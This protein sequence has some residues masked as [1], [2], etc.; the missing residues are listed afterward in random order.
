MAHGFIGSP[1]YDLSSACSEAG[2]D[3]EA[4]HPSPGDRDDDGLATAK[5]IA[6]KLT[7]LCRAAGA[8][9]AGLASFLDNL[10]LMV[11]ARLDRIDAHGNAP[12]H[13]LATWQEN[14][15]KTLMT[16]EL[17]CPPTLHALASAC[18]MSANGFAR[19]FRGSTGSSP[20]QWLISFRIARAQEMLADSAVPLSA[21]ALDCGFCDQSHFTHS[22][23]ELVGKTP[24]V[25][26]REARHRAASLP[27]AW[28]HQDWHKSVACA[29]E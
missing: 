29:A 13:R 5:L 9:D 18:G 7:T 12:S 20:R 15:A 26:R 25:W 4:R 10:L 16:Q 27:A 28:E 24:S 23:T 14:A 6:T 17:T 8:G 21:I 22:F 11:T 1:W 19:A 2:P 3:H